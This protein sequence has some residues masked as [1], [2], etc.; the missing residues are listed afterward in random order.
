MNDETRRRERFPFGLAHLG[1]ETVERDIPA[2][3]PPALAPNAELNLIGKS[4]PR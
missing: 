1:L 2:G 3:E 4:I